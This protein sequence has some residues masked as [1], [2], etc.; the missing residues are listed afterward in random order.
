MSAGCFVGVICTIVHHF[1]KSTTFRHDAFT[2]ATQRAIVMNAFFFSRNLLL[3]LTL[4]GLFVIS[5]V[6]I[7]FS[8][9]AGILSGTSYFPSIAVCSVDFTVLL[10]SKQLHLS[11]PYL[12]YRINKMVPNTDNSIIISKNGKMQGKKGQREIEREKGNSS[13]FSLC[14]DEDADKWISSMFCRI[15]LLISI[16]LQF[17]CVCMCTI[18]Y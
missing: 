18:F 4:F 2:L 14:I 16:A 1:D 17:N 7:I 13:L 15:R 11:T 6:F 9:L 12:I 8:C 10:S 3:L 5:F